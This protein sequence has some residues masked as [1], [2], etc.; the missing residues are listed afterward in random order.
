LELE[1]L[2]MD[3]SNTSEEIEIKRQVLAKNL[4]ELYERN[5]DLSPLIIIL[6]NQKISDVISELIVF[7]KLAKV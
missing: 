2:Q 6:K 1:Q 5:K 7:N 4:Q 3:I